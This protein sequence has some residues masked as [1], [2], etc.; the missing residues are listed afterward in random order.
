MDYEFNNSNIVLD[1]IEDINFENLDFL[2]RYEFMIMY[3]G[4]RSKELYWAIEITSAVQNLGQSF[5]CLG[6]L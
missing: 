3:T 2:H 1:P 5:D 6:V 4:K